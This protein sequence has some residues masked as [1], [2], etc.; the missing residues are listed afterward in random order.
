[1]EQ[2]YVYSWTAEERSRTQIRAYGIDSTGDTVALI[3]LD[4]TPYVYIELPNTPDWKLVLQDLDR[5]LSSKVLLTKVVE[6]Q[7]LYSSRGVGKFLFCQCSSRK[8]IGYISF[9][10]RQNTYRGHRLQL[11][12]DLATSVL[13]LTSLRQVPMATWLCY[14]G[15]L[16]P[17]SERQTRCDREVSVSWR[18]LHPSTETRQVK[19]K[20]LAFDLEVNSDQMN[21]MPS[22]KPGDEIFQISC[23]IEDALG[24]RKLLLTLEGTDLVENS[25]LNGITVYTYENEEELISGFINLLTEERPNVLA[26]YNILMFDIVYLIQRCERYGMLDE[27]LK[28]GFNQ[29]VPAEKRS[30]KWSSS[31]FKNQEYTFIEW[32]GIF[33]ADL[34]P[35]IKRDYKFENYKLDTVA[36]A[37][38]GAEKDPVNYKEIFAA[39]RSRKLA[40][41]GK[42]CVQDSNLC[43]D[44]FNH[45]QCWISLAEMAMVCRVCMFSLYT[46]G[47]QLKIY[48][49]VYDYC[50]RKNIVV[51]SNGYEC[52]VGERYLGAYVMDPVPGIYENVCPLDFAS[53]YPSIIIAYNICYSTFVS[54]ATDVDPATYNT[55]EWED[56]LGCEHDPKVVSVA[57][58]TRQIDALNA[59]IAAAVV[60]RNA[61]R[62]VEVKQ[63]IQKR[64]NELK[65][66]Q[67][68]LREKRVELKKGKPSDR[69]DAEGNVITGVVCARRCYR[70]LKP[71]VKVG[72]IPT[73]IQNLLNSRRLVRERMKH[74]SADERVVLDKQQLAHKVSANSQYGAMGVRRGMLPFMPGA[75]CIT[76]LGRE[77]IAKAGSIVCSKYGGNWIYTD[78]D[79]TYVTFPLL[80]TP[81]EIWDNAIEVAKLVSNEFPG[82]TIEFEQAV[83][84]KFIILSK[85][86]YMYVS[87]NREGVTDDKI[88]KRGVVLARRDNTPYL[89]CAYSSVVSMV[90]K[91]LCRSDIELYLIEYISDMFRRQTDSRQFIATKSIGST[92][93]DDTSGR[94]GD[95]KVK[96]LPTDATERAKA[97]NGKTERQYLIDSCP[98]QV[99]LAEKMRLR[100]FPVDVGSRLEFVVLESPNAKT[101]GG[102][103]EDGDYYLRRRTLLRLDYL[104]YLKT[105]VNPLDQLLKVA[106]GSDRFVEQQLRYR[107]NHSK[108][109]RQL[110][111]L[112]KP[113][114]RKPKISKQAAAVVKPQLVAAPARC[115]NSVSDFFATLEPSWRAVLA[116]ELTRDYVTPLVTFVCEQRQRYVVFPP[117]K[118]IFTWSWQTLP[119]AVSVVIIGQDP[120]HGLNQANGLAFSVNRQIPIPPS[121]ANIYTEL[122]SDL[123]VARPA[124]G[125]LAAWAKQGVLMINSV[126]TV[127][128]GYA[129][130][131]AGKGWEKFTTAVI[132]W[133]NSNT[134]GVVFL[135]FGAYAQSKASF[136]DKKRHAVIATAHP[137]PF[138]AHTGFFG[139]KPF[140]QCNALLESFGKPAI[141]WSL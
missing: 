92:D 89:R 46:Q 109:I 60:R 39:F 29:Q 106:T 138:S 41:V 77:A 127:Q 116:Q 57:D 84:K 81:E 103:I 49:Q 80:K 17:E 4:F 123:A 111:T 53:L 73:I 14:R 101:L 27:L 76:Y 1:M 99:Q 12:E 48:N 36:S 86:R 115:G 87:S 24:R 66:Q 62:G 54:S 52:H 85:K 64:I 22:N 31:A 5:D 72:V 113:L 33:L 74:C 65:L 40:R 23:V 34:L 10:L 112:F 71:E 19:P 139:S 43:V 121:L 7:H 132:S 26:G 47:Q 44:L 135:L 108:L 95:Y 18:N 134:T 122:Q 11:H 59:K 6:R 117:P 129:G 93:G 136:I 79:S 82:L 56:H 105:L 130:S 141:N 83:Y 140:S 58:L 100:G 15:T 13:Q 133:I 63:Q 78:T 50:L 107:T 3:I 137:S 45:I 110:Q 8:Q 2:L 75:M 124:H 51:T 68:P 126:L 96:Q 118:Q 97:L 42:Y 70:F 90:F 98:A 61:A 120:Y 30:I 37:L 28:A 102:K 35:I 38:V 131:H 114:I 16:V 128:Q 91:G 94:L 69:E 104:Y 21:A 25:L 125:D 20:V 32:E 55:F 67:K 119:K 88:G 9:M